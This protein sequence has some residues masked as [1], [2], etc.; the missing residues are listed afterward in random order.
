MGA[1]GDRR[2]PPWLVSPL[3]QGGYGAGS[4]GTYNTGDCGGGC[5]CGGPLAGLG[6]PRAQAQ[7][8]FLAAAPFGGGFDWGRERLLQS[9][10][11]LRSP[12]Y[13]LPP[14]GYGFGYGFGYGW[15]YFIEPA[16]L[17]YPY[18]SFAR[19]PVVS[20]VTSDQNS[21]TP[22]VIGSPSWTSAPRPNLTQTGPC[23]V[24]IQDLCRSPGP[25]SGERER[26]SSPSYIGGTSPG[27]T[28]S[29]GLRKPAGSSC[30]DRRRPD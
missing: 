18:F 19:Y 11:P 28:R 27:R 7:V 23:R 13:P 9:V 10:R 22:K 15:P 16:P 6:V 3:N 21:P 30:F 2:T 5:G 24:P 29:A 26:R 12:G 4:D 1:G 14:Y 20:Y 8:S 17:P 25:G